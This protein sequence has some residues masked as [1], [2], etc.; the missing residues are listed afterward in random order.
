MAATAEKAVMTMT[1]KRER[2][3]VE[4]NRPKPVIGSFG[5]RPFDGSKVR[6][7]SNGDGT[8]R[9]EAAGRVFKRA[10]IRLGRPLYDP[11]AFASIMNEKGK[12]L[13]LIFR[14]DHMPAASRQ[15]L[16]E[17]QVGFDLTCQI[18]R[19]VSLTHQ[20]GAAFW[21]VET[22]KG[23]REF[24]IRGTT[25][26]IRWLTDDRMLI[27]DVNGTRF[28]IKSLN[29]LDKKSQTQIHLLL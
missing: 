3:A 23:L 28:E 24:V 7:T 22:N 19:V 10:R 2:A 12:E 27:T 5:T 29:G 13:G 15:V 8:L 17:Y 18:L 1:R 25:E 16:A 9:V 6:L 4:N 11:N 20:F 26:H 21:E 14:V